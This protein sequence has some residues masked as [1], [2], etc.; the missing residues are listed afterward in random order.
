MKGFDRARRNDPCPC[1]SGRK[2]KQCCLPREDEFLELREAGTAL[3][4]LLFRSLRIREIFPGVED[5]WRRYWPAEPPLSLDAALTRLEHDGGNDDDVLQFLD[6]LFHDA[7]LGKLPADLPHRAAG[8]EQ[9]TFLDVIRALPAM[10][11]VE[12]GGSPSPAG[13]VLDAFRNSRPSVYQVVQIDPGRGG[14]LRDA[15][16]DEVF[17][18]WDVSMSRGSVPGDVLFLRLRPLAGVYEVASDGWRFPAT[19]LARL[20]AW[21]ELQLARLREF[22]PDA[23]WRRLWRA[24]GELLHHYVVE[25]RDHPSLPQLFTTTG[26]RLICCAVEWEIIDR[27]ALEAA[28]DRLADIER[29]GEDPMWTWLPRPGDG[30]WVAHDPGA[31]QPSFETVLPG[32]PALGSLA[33]EQEG[34]K[35]PQLVLQCLSEERLAAGRA[36]VEQA[37]GQ[38]LGSV[39]ER[40]LAP[41]EAV[42]A[43]R[44]RNQAGSAGEELP[45]DVQ[46][47]LTATFMRDYERRWVDMRIPALGGK[48]PRQAA[49]TADPA[50]RRQ[51]ADL[52]LEMENQERWTAGTGGLGAGMSV[53]RVRGLLG[54]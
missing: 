42:A 15:F 51:L 26:E 27:A 30:R 1:G 20:R 41:E 22:E 6:W 12:Q 47:E 5:A 38:H 3:A 53:Q 45:E 29:A 13:R 16:S 40:R 49:A 7:P 48:T 17:E 28:L 21:A 24:R 8:G 50:L 35:G 52:L 54:L 23:N 9:P 10:R 43:A 32:G 18:V 14:R 19:E 25:R 31:T 11:E 37:A 39:T 4:A 33:I 36:M 34:G 2:Y 46:R 44:E